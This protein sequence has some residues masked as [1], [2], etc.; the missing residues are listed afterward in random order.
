MSDSPVAA[1]ARHFEIPVLAVAVFLS[2]FIVFQSSAFFFTLSDFFFSIGMVLTVLAGRLPLQPLGRATAF[3]LLSY[4][5]LLFGLIASSMF[6][7][8]PERSLIIAGQYSFAY[9]LLLFVLTGRDSATTHLLIQFFVAGI[10][11]A[12]LIGITVFFSET[13]IGYPVVTGGGRLASFLMNPNAN[14]NLIALTIP[15][16]LYL[17]ASGRMSLWLAVP[18]MLILSTALVCASSV[19]GLAAAV[20]AFVFF[21]VT[22]GLGATLRMLAVAACATAIAFVIW[23]RND[24]AMPEIFEK[25]VMGAVETGDLEHAGTFSSRLDLMVEAAGMVGHTLLFGIGA[26][27]YREVSVH[28]APVH[29]VYLLIWAEGGLPALIGW[30]ALMAV[31]VLGA[32]LVYHAGDRRRLPVASLGITFAAVFSMGAMNTPHRYGRYWSVPLLLA[33]ALLF[34]RAEP[35]TDDREVRRHV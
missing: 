34:L 4:C 8:T 5:L 18:A 22:T 29:N 9:L 17:W 2:P 24:Y 3:W 16:I 32:I 14:A 35:R 13:E 12:N 7:P 1:L 11:T 20:I 27:R 31:P 15:F 33:I 26:D 19:N 25:R 23:S 21:F 10:V 6:N 30:L 28:E